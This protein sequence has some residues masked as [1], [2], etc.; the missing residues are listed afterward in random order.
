MH[1]P[2]MIA[3]RDFLIFV[4]N[5]KWNKRLWSILGAFHKKSDTTG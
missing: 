1:F 5:L 4:E 3:H 2:D